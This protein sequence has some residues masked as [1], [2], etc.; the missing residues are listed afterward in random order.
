MFLL[1]CNCNNL[2]VYFDRGV[3]ED[4]FRS[5]RLR[6]QSMSLL[7][8]LFCGNSL[9]EEVELHDDCEPHDQDVFL[10]CK[11]FMH[12]TELSQKPLFVLPAGRLSSLQ[13]SGPSMV[14]PRNDLGER[15]RHEFR[16]TARAIAERPWSLTAAK[17]YLE[18]LCD[19]N[20]AQTWPRP[21]VLSFINTPPEDLVTLVDQRARAGIPNELADF[22]PG[23]PRRVVVAQAK[24]KAEGRG[25]GSGRGGRGAGRG[26]GAAR[27][28]DAEDGRAAGDDPPDEPPDPPTARVRRMKRPASAYRGERMPAESAP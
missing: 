23:T 21:P 16:K 11:Q 25:R 28:A 5:S 17:E 27:D 4:S 24:P 3:V 15:T 9:L 13:P 12:S 6:G 10:L 19:N 18:L 20:E 2:L 7:Q 1:C 8:L 26:R 14:C 22:A